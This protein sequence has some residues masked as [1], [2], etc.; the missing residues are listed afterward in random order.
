M[1]K[2]VV[3][4]VVALCMLFVTLG[5]TAQDEWIPGLAS[6]VLPGLGQLLN[7]Q[8]DKAIL[9]FAVDI[10]ILAIGYYVGTLFPFGFY[11]LPALHLG[12]AIYSGFDAYNV[13]KDQG[14]SI[15]FIENGVQLS[16]GF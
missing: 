14:F 15:G 11:A 3:V 2:G 10:G 4:G 12:W 13:A 6:F 16:Y 8:M 7:D 5:V 1:R 9:H